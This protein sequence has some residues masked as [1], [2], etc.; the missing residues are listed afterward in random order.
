[1]KTEVENKEVLGILENDKTNFLN[2]WQG[3]FRYG[4]FDLDLFKKTIEKDLN[5]L[6]IENY[7]KSICMTHLDETDGFI[8]TEDKKRLEDFITQFND[9]GF[10]LSYSENSQ[11]IVYY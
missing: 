5:D 11:N 8:I 10:Y 3:I 1:M 7:K 2:P 9:F 6:E 4:Y